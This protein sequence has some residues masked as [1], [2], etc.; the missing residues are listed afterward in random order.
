M[1]MN[2]AKR[3]VFLLAAVLC[4]SRPVGAQDQPVV[5]V[6]GL[7]GNAGTWANMRDFLQAQLQIAGS[8]PTLGWGNVYGAQSA[9]LHTSLQGLNNVIAIGHSNGGVVTRNYLVFNTAPRINRHISV[10]SPHRGATLAAKALDGDLA[11][12]VR[13]LVSAVTAPINFYLVRDSWFQDYF[14]FMVSTVNVVLGAFG[15]VEDNMSFLGF[16]TSFLLQQTFGF[17]PDVLQ[18]MRPGANSVVALQL[19]PSALQA[20]ASRTTRRFSISNELEPDLQP[21]SIMFGNASGL[22]QTLFT[23][24]GTAQSLYW[25]YSEH[26]NYEL[27][28]MAFLWQQLAVTLA[29]LPVRWAELNGS[30]INPSQQWKNDGIVTWESSR[31]PG[32]DWYDMPASLFPQVPH[33]SQT[34]SPAVGDALRLILTS[35][36][37]VAER[38]APP[39]TYSANIIGPTIVAGGSTCTFSAS[40]TGGS[41]PYTYQWFVEQSPVSQTPSFSWPFGGVSTEVSLTVT[42]ASGASRSASQ[43]VFVDP[44]A[45]GCGW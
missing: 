1:T 45:E 29:A 42:D 38:G 12:F 35:Q 28:Q 33:T 4:L 8:T 32:G 31:Y 26:P 6:H 41:P 27:R 7:T 18:E 44:Y 13:D 36:M 40:V 17:V 2:L 15:S 24:I 3:S 19:T 20:E 34:T 11:D 30:L 5:F 9:N 23:L 43:F 25:Y 14:S 10:N 16:G 21:F 37:G 39:P 22:Q